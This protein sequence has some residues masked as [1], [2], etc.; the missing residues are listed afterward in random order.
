ME[1]LEASTDEEALKVSLPARAAIL[2]RRQLFS[3][4]AKRETGAAFLVKF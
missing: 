1:R 3:T 2:R 4:C